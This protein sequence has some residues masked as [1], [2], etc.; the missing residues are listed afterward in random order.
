M[1]IHLK[2]HAEECKQRDIISFTVTVV[3]TQNG[4]EIDSRGVST[5]I[6]IV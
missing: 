4:E 2:L 1:D 3:E 5:I 6:H